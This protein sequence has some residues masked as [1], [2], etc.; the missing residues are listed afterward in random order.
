M[1]AT[2]TYPVHVMFQT[3]NNIIHLHSIFNFPLLPVYMAEVLVLEMRSLR[4]EQLNNSA[5][6]ALNVTPGFEQTL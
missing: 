4:Q 1:H 3:S 5:K 2:F 6:I